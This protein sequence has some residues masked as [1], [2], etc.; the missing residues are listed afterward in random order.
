MA[1]KI[2]KIGDFCGVGFT[3]LV[4]GKIVKFNLV[5]A[6]CDK[7]WAKYEGEQSL[8]FIFLSENERFYVESVYSG[9]V[10]GFGFNNYSVKTI[11]DESFKKYRIL[12]SNITVINQIAEAEEEWCELQVEKEDEEKKAKA[13]RINALPTVFE[14]GL[15][16]LVFVRGK[17][18]YDRKF[19]YNIKGSNIT[20]KRTE[21]NDNYFYT[22]GGYKRKDGS[23]LVKDFHKSFY[24]L[25]GDVSKKEVKQIMI[26]I[27]N[28]QNEVKE[29]IK[30]A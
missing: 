24:D 3:T 16:G 21:L 23:L 29:L 4:N 25:I 22:L 17:A 8:E 28:R 10:T 30:N 11:E 15:P 19:S 7:L 12:T 18:S 14:S 1:R 26:N 9:G 2:D 13:E 20:L 27:S 6:E 5:L